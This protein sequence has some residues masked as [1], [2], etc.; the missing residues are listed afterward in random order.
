MAPRCL[1]EKNFSDV[2]KVFVYSKQL[3][4]LANLR[5]LEAVLVSAELANHYLKFKTRSLN[6]P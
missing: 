5:C 1:K 2:E 6:S 4:K 3:A